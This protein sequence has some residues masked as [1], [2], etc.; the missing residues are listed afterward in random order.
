MDASILEF[1]AGSGAWSQ[2][3]LGIQGERYFCL[4][5]K[6][7]GT[8]DNT[9]MTVAM[10]AAIGSPED[11]TVSSPILLA[12]SVVFSKPQ[13]VPSLSF[14]EIFIYN[15]T[16]CSLYLIHTLGRETRINYAFLINHLF[17]FSSV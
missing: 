10:I 12:F 8:G 15:H 13:T 6:M 17:L 4:K 3:H 14:P 16:L 5:E 2:P 11:S 9:T 7:C 1:A